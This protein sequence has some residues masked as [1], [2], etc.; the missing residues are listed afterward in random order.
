MINQSSAPGNLLGGMLLVA[1]S[2]IGAG[3]LALPIL[4]GLAGFIPSLFVLIYIRVEFMEIRTVRAGIWNT[5]DLV[6]GGIMFGLVMEFAR[7]KYE[8]FVADGLSQGRQPL[9]TGGG[10]VRSAG[11]WKE[12]IALR[13]ADIQMHSDERILGDSDFVN[14]GRIRATEGNVN[15]EIPEGTDLTKYKNVLI[16]CRAF[17]VLFSYATF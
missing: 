16:W 11:G 15:Y 14:L 12:L 2:C 4:T 17:S 8:E 5:T 1:G 3:M 13:R 10:L 7:K 6:V 9:L